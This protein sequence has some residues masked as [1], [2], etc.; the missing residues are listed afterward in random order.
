M[1]N[2][3]RLPKREGMALATVSGAAERVTVGLDRDLPLEEKIAALDALFDAAQVPTSRR[4]V[5]LGVLL[6]TARAYDRSWERGLVDLYVAA[7]A[8]P[9]T[10]AAQEATHREII[11]HRRGGPRH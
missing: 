10:A 1:V 8:D 5:L 6:G 3:G 4:P 9:K 7:G 2:I 11:A